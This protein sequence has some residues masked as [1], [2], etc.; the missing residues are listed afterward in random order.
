MEFWMEK[1]ANDIRLLETRR[2]AVKGLQAQ[3]RMLEADITSLPGVSAGSAPVQ[4]GGNRQEVR[5]CGYVDRKTVL[6]KQKRALQ[7]MIE[8]TEKILKGM[9]PTDRAILTAFYLSDQ[10]RGD[11]VRELEERYHISQSCVYR[12]RDRAL[13]FFAERMGYC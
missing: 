10:Y 5:L 3:I 2:E 1:A 12:Y 11:A 9:D 6:E 7:Q 4:G 8:H 13:R